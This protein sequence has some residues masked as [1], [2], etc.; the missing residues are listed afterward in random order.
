VKTPFV[1]FLASLV[2]A[3][4]LQAAATVD[5]SAHTF[6][7]V[8]DAS[9]T[10]L[11]V[12]DVV[13]IGWFNASDATLKGDAGNYTALS[14]LF[15]LY[16]TGHIGDGDVAGTAGYFADG[17]T[18]STGSLSIGGDQIYM[19]IF[20]G[21]NPATATQEGIF[22]FNKA[23]SSHWAFPVDGPPAGNT[24]IDLADLTGALTGSGSNTL[25]AGN[26]PGGTPIADV[27]IGSFGPASIAT[28]FNAKAFELAAA[29]EPATAGLA[30]F[31]GLA[32]LLRRRRTA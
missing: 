16:A 28:P 1:S 5:F 23:S 24:S 27:V 22:Y 19:W 6:N 30:I 7:G 9:G 12:G 8:T 15:T 32:V 25:V 21:S 3:A 20:N 10:A 29:P 2:A 31:G 4:S 13:E 14:Q 26:A 17:V 11:P 18:A